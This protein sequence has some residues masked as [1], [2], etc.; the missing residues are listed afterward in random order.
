MIDQPDARTLLEAMAAT[1]TD[2]VMPELSGGAQH[3]AR[4]VANLCRVVARD[5]ADDPTETTAALAGLLGADGSLDDL[6]A[7]LDQRLAGG[8]LLGDAIPI[9]LADAARRAEVAKPGYT[10]GLV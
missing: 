8:E 9:L 7:E 2:T 1:L 3:Q 6:A 10:D 4:I 5:L